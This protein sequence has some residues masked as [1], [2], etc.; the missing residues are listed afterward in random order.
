MKKFLLI[1]FLFSLKFSFSQD[2][3]TDLQLAQYYFS[4]Q[5]FEKALPYCQKVYAKDNSKFN[6][7]RL[8]ECLINTNNEKDAEKILKKQIS[9]NR[10]DFE[11][12]IILANLYLKQEKPKDA[13]KIYKELIDEYAISSY[14]IIPLYQAFR[15]ANLTDYAFQA[16]EKGR[17]SMKTNFPLN[18]QFAELYLLNKETDKMIDEYLSF[19]E[20]NTTNIDIVQNSLARNI[21]FSIESNAEVDLLKEK[22]LSK[23]QKKPNDFVY[24]E[25]LIWLLIQRKQFNAALIQSQAL[26]KREQGD[27][28]R[29]LDLGNMCL[30]NNNYKVAKDAYKYVI[31][32]GN[33]KQFYFSAEYALLNASYT[34]LIEQRNFDQIEIQKTLDEYKKVID[35][36][37]INVKSV[38]IIKQYTYIQAYFANQKEKAVELISEVLKLPGLTS[39]QQAELKMQKADIFVLLDDIWESSL[40]YMQVDKDFK[41]EPIGFEAKF[42]NARIFYYDG[43]F[44][45]AQSQLDILKQSTTKLI[46][47]DAMKLSILITDNYGLDSN[48]TAMSKFAQA[49]LFLEQHQ[50]EK[51]FELYD[52]I[53]LAFPYHGLSDEILLRKAKAMQEQGKWNDAVNYLN[54]LLKYHAKDILADDALFQ[55]ASI[56]EN[57]L[58]DNEKASEFYKKILF[59][60][61]GS[62]YTSEARKRFRVLRGDEVEEL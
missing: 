6:F 20:L 56:Y 11:F 9:S 52:T 2:S 10:E 22:L 50:Y 13:Q 14:T 32:L 12:P 4:N 30:Q 18:I 40:L 34:E 39:M 24:S 8:Y 27:G 54:E 29:V 38:E 15:Q 44:E 36:I 53:V 33:D 26:D 60:Y 42:K 5:E 7:K 16:L 25:M 17:K 59:D 46:A 31:S 37:G 41:F 23:V 21:D 3:G 62:L 19:L 28:I 58:M 1:C 55:L 45:F 48:Y 35:R 49:D 61:K 43:D 57:N 47:N 51:A